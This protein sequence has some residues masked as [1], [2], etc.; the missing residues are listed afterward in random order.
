MP[1]PLKVIKKFSKNL[2]K[3]A[4]LVIA[5]QNFLFTF[6]S[7][8]QIAANFIKKVTNLKNKKFLEISKYFI[9]NNNKYNVNNYFSP[10]HNNIEILN[11]LSSLSILKKKI[12]R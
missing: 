10:K 5:T 2:N 12:M 8:S 4:Y 3:N 7:F 9:K 11:T 1:N 6:V